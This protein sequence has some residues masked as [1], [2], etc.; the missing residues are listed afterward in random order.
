VLLLLI[1]GRITGA[2][3]VNDNGNL[4]N[5]ANMNGGNTKNGN[6]GSWS[7]S[8]GI[9]SK[10]NAVRENLKNIFR[11]LN[12]NS[13]NEV[14]DQLTG[15]PTE[16]QGEN[17]NGEGEHGDLEMEPPSRLILDDADAAEVWKDE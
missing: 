5:Y 16:R 14:I 15:K 13:K 8:N 7:E 1:L 11:G 4:N 6:S 17:E 2:A 12:F 3:G 10:T 9:N